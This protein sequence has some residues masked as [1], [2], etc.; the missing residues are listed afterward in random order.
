MSQK[1]QKQL[2]AYHFTLFKQRYENWRDGEE[3]H[4][5]NP[6]FLIK[7]P[8]RVLGVE[9][10][11][12]VK[13]EADGQKISPQQRDGSLQTIVR[14]AEMQYRERRNSPLLVG[15]WFNNAFTEITKKTTQDVS[16]RI[17]QFVES[18]SAND[19]PGIYYPKE[20]PEV[21]RISVTPNVPEHCAKWEKQQ[22]AWVR[23]D[24]TEVLQGF[25]D[26]KNEK[27][28]TYIAKCKVCW[29]LIVVDQGKPGKSF[30]DDKNSKV[31]EHTYQSKFARTFFM[32][33][34]GKPIELKTI[35]TE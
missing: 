16:S 2:E 32:E 3:D 27:Y 29:L 18:A 13:P 25:I 28:N 1:E 31:F 10:E 22:S 8:S 34:T 21:D 12:F 24:F 20:L 33:V 17:A 5:D 6:D 9:H 11:E 7:Y 35:S 30:T 19:C 26:K 15:I 23:N 4:D 14:K